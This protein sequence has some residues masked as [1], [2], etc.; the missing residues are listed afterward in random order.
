M[1]RVL[2]IA[3]HASQHFHQMH[4]DLTPTT[5]VLLV[6]TPRSM[7]P[8]DCSVIGYRFC[9]WFKWLCG[10]LRAEST[11]LAVLRRCLAPLGLQEWASIDVYREN[12]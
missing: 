3:L 10:A 2:F 9:G 6:Y 11:L 5:P 7:S 8:S 1:W 4:R 12:T